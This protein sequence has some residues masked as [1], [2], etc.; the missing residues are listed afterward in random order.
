MTITHDVFWTL[1]WIACGF[2]VVLAGGAVGVCY[3]IR[4]C[5]SRWH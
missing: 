5:L 3:F 4:Y 1:L 2:I